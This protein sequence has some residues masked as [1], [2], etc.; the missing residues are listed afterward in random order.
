MGS[1]FC[2]KI[3]LRADGA[4]KENAPYE[5][6]PNWHDVRPRD[7]AVLRFKIVGIGRRPMLI[8]CRT[9]L[10]ILHSRTVRRPPRG[11]PPQKAP[12]E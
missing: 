4:E 2:P 11:R 5:S 9:D 10:L 8:Q 12:S 7:K 1:Q 3:A 6:N